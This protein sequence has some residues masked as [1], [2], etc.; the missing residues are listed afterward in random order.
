MIEAIWEAPRAEREQVGAIVGPERPDAAVAV[1]PV[2]GR[3]G[4]EADQ[5]DQPLVVGQR[6]RPSCD[7]VGGRDPLG[8]IHAEPAVGVDGVPRLQHRRD[9]RLESA[10]GRRARR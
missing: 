5:L 8:A 9:V 1:S 10:G 3:H 4:G 2:P 6:V 7:L